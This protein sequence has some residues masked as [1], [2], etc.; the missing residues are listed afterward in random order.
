MTIQREGRSRALAEVVGHIYLSREFLT[1]MTFLRIV[2]SL[3]LLFEHDLSENRY[4]L[5][6][7]ML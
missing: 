5:F 4:P 6:R 2:I 7:I 3:Y 1:Q